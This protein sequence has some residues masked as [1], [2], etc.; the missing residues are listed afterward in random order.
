MV[1][2]ICMLQNLFRYE[3]PTILKNETNKILEDLQILKTNNLEEQLKTKILED[4]HEH[5][6]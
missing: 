3:R 1:G 5:F 4:L 6:L 2:V